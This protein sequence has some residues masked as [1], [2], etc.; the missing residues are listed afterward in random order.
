MALSHPKGI[1]LR[2]PGKKKHFPPRDP[3]RITVPPGATS[4]TASFTASGVPAA[5]STSDGGASASAAWRSEGDSRT[6]QACRGG[7]GWPR[8]ATDGHGWPRM[9]TDGH[10]WPRMATDGHGWPIRIIL[11]HR[12]FT[13][14]CWA[15]IETVWGPKAFKRNL[16]W[17]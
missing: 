17:Q 2:H 13:L 5:S 12:F 3:S 8:M 4:D 14:L 16:T 10:G 6:F 11:G 1:Q 9:A 7:Y 15:K